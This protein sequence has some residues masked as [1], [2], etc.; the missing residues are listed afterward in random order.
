ML[1]GKSAACFTPPLKGDKEGLCGIASAASFPIKISDNHP[2]PEM[3]DL[4]GWTECSVG[5]SCSCSFSFFGLFC[6]W[7]DW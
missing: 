6:L 1:D 4:F 5:S 7:H 2:V 3:C